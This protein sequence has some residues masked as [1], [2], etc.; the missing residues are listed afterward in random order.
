MVA[1]ELHNLCASSSRTVT[2]YGKL[3]QRLETHP[4]EAA[5]ECDDGRLPLHLLL[6]WTPSLALVQTLLTAYPEAAYCYESGNR[7]FP[8]QIACRAGCAPDVV[9]YLVTSNPRAL[10]YTTRNS[11][12]CCLH[13]LC[14]QSIFTS[15][16]KN[17]RGGLSCL[18][19]VER[20]PLDHPHRASLIVV[21][22]EHCIHPV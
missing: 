2:H 19:L 7:N 14:F 8:L 18:D 16:R 17:R 21:L 12:L 6:Q 10:A 15:L 22:E 4:H 20:L 3:L 1:K 9:T 5:E 11:Y 13:Q